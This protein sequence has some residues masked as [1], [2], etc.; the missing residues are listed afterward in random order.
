MSNPATPRMRP[1][2]SERIKFQR[3]AIL[4]IIISAISCL[5]PSSGKNHNQN[6]NVITIFNK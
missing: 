6:T 4:I 5:K 3:M 2:Y 1:L